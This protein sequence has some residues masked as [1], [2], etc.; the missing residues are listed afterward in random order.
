MLHLTR[1][2]PFFGYTIYSNLF[3]AFSV[4]LVRRK[5]VVGRGF[6]VTWYGWR[7]VLFSLFVLLLLLFAG[8]GY[9][10]F[11]VKLLTLSL[12]VG[13]PFGLIGALLISPP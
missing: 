4:A 11:N 10:G 5:V 8:V 1:Y 12:P 3:T 9:P 6:T 2:V 13:I 7:A